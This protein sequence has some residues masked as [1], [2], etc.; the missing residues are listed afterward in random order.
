MSGN[1]QQNYIHGWKAICD[2]LGQSEYRIK[3]QRYPIYRMPE[4]RAVWAI[5]EELDAHT[6]LLFTRSREQ[7]EQQGMSG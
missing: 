5:P 4:S 7:V 2:Y 3:R 1:Q 6:V